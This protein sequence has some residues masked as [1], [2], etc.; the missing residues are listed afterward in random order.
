MPLSNVACPTLQ[1][2]W[3]IRLFGFQSKDNQ[4]FQIQCLIK[5]KQ[6]KLIKG[7]EI[8]ESDKIFRITSLKKIN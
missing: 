7:S 4:L 3:N 5:A 6:L 1:G 8:Q 2:I